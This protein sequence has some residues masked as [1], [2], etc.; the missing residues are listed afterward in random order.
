MKHAVLW[1][2]IAESVQKFEASSL[3]NGQPIDLFLLQLGHNERVKIAKKL[4][5]VDR[6][7]DD[8]EPR[9]IETDCDGKQ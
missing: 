9:P 4:L 3:K 2:L 1:N 8:T 6:K 7:L 5:I